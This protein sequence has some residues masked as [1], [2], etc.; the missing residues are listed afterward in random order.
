M[1]AIKYFLRPVAHCDEGHYEG[2][3]YDPKLPFSL[4]KDT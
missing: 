1:I 3:G 2:P 4:K